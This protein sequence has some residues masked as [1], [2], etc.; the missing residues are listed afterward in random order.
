MKR[1]IIAGIVLFAAFF[2][3]FSSSVYVGYSYFDSLSSA[4]QITLQIGEWDMAPDA[5]DENTTYS[6]GDQITYNGQVYE[7]KHT[8]PA[9]WAPDDWFGSWFWKKIS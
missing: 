7:A 5:W 3:I 8:V 9:G 4:N 1:K 2:M 6:K